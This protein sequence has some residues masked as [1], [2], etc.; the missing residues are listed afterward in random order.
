MN[1][2]PRPVENSVISE[3]RRGRTSLDVDKLRASGG[4]R[5]KSRR[6]QRRAVRKGATRSEQVTR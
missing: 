4:G 1:H 6:A 5:V 2:I 3:V